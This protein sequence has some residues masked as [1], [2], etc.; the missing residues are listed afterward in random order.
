MNEYIH[1]DE[2]T[3]KILDI[4][5]WQQNITNQGF[6]YTG[7]K[8]WALNRIR[9]LLSEAYNR[10]VEDTKNTQ[11]YKDLCERALEI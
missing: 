9:D 1:G 2:M 7:E 11:E 8:D 10:G 6:N 4:L 5:A 3:V